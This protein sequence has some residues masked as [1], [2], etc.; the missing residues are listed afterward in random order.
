MT[1]D[2]NLCEPYLEILGTQGKKNRNTNPETGMVITIF[3]RKTRTSAIFDRNRKDELPRLQLEWIDSICMPLY[4]VLVK[5]NGKLQPM[6]DSVVANRRKWEELH[7][8]RL[9][10][11]AAV[12]ATALSPSSSSDLEDV[13]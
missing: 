6:L 7:Q 13:N 4:Q 9:L 12:V 1:S 3:Q 8:K 5:V 2:S 10:S 11:Q